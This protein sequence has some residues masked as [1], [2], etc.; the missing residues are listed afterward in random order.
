M[1]PTVEWWLRRGTVNARPR[2]KQRASDSAGLA[3]AE[4]NRL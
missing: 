4:L 3:A 2:E 1:S